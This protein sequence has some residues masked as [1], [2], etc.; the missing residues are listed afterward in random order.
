MSV[1]RSART[2]TVSRADLLEKVAHSEGSSTRRRLVST[3][4]PKFLQPVSGRR[5]KKKITPT[6]RIANIKNSGEWL[7][8]TLPSTA[9][10]KLDYSKE[11]VEEAP[12]KEHVALSGS[13]ASSEHFYFIVFVFTI[14]QLA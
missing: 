7:D 6:R 8:E 9:L 11:S 13:E 1:R 5:L 4:E 3:Q 10:L 12:Q 2:K 14:N